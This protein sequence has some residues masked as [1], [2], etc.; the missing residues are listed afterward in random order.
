[1]PAAR[2]GGRGCRQGR[3]VGAG[4]MRPAG[5]AG[6]RG[7]TGHAVSGDGQVSYVRGAAGRLRAWRAGPLCAWRCGPAA[8]V[9]RGPAR[10]RRECR[11]ECAES[12]RLKLRAQL[13]NLS[14]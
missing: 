4:W 9:T 7:W 5:S 11:R 3:G 12:D 14:I 13:T 8:C 2:A 10:Y 1:M 6:R